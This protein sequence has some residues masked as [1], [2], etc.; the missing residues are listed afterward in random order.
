MFSQLNQIVLEAKLNQTTR[1]S[2]RE[3]VVKMLTSEW[4]STLTTSPVYLYDQKLYKH[5]LQL[6]NACTNN[7]L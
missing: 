1:E 3:Q 5:N 2:K 4:N 6:Y 7:V